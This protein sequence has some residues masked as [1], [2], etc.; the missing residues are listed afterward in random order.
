MMSEPAD[1]ITKKEKRDTVSMVSEMMLEF[2]EEMETF[3]SVGTRIAAQTRLIM[4]VV[5]GALAL[6]SLYLGFMIYHMSN[7]M[8]AMTAHLIDMYS[9]FGVMS[10]NMS[11][12]TQSVGLMNKSIIGMP[13]I[14][15]SMIQIDGDVRAMNGSVFE[16]NKSISNIDG[17]MVRINLNMQ[18]MTIGLVNMNRAVYSMSNDV[19]EM[20]APVNSGPF[21]GMWPR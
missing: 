7:N 3:N 15:D 1:D 6:S 4:R 5:F 12:I 20:Q 2:R 11:Q 19:N 13:V 17:E 18:D 16:M 21:S 8:S 9:N 10:K 14:A